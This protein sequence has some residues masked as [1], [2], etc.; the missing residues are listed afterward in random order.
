MP[1]RGRAVRVVV[2]LV[3]QRDVH[4]KAKWVRTRFTPVL[5]NIALKRKGFLKR[6]GFQEQRRPLKPDLPVVKAKKET[7]FWPFPKTS[8]PFIRPKARI[9][10]LTRGLAPLIKSLPLLLACF[11]ENSLKPEAQP[12]PLAPANLYYPIDHIVAP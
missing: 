11:Q 9:S 1:A 6:E 2:V 5:K 4:G 7:L 3:K 8:G 10:V 12:A